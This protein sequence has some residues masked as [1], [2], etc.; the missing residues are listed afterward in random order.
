MTPRHVLR[1]SPSVLRVERTHNPCPYATV[2]NCSLHSL[3]FSCPIGE[4]REERG[5]GDISRVYTCARRHA[6]PFRGELFQKSESGE[7]MHASASGP[8][9][10]MGTSGTPRPTPLPRVVGGGRSVSTLSTYILQMNISH[11]LDTRTRVRY[12]LTIN[13]SSKH[14]SY[15]AQG[16]P[17]AKHA[18]SQQCS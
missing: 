16:A 13:Y 18:E 2:M 4:E 10:A 12:Q 15:D 3:S 1:W 8:R 9:P 17:R 14:C 7:N 6:F 11:A 5:G